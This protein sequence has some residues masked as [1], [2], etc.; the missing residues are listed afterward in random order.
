MGLRRQE[1]G[2]VHVFSNV[3][4]RVSR[5]R[6]VVMEAKLCNLFGWGRRCALAE[7]GMLSKL[8]VCR[9]V[10]LLLVSPKPADPNER[11]SKHT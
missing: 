11:A 6:L 3:E 9:A 8:P 2:A 1:C 4:G 10:R 5:R 7:D